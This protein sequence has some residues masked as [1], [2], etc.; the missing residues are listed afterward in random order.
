M[1]KEFDIY[2][3]KRLTKCDI[4]VYSIPYR[5]GLTAMSRLIL[6]SCL[7]EYTLQKFIAVQT[8]STL[9]SHIDQMIKTCYE[10]LNCNT[11]FDVSVDFQTHYA[12]YPASSPLEI[13]AKDVKMLANSFIEAKNEMLISAAPLL[14]FVGKSL[15]RGNSTIVTDANLSGTLKRSIERGDDIVCFDASV[16]ETNVQKLLR[17]D[18]P[19][20]LNAEVVNLCYRITNLVDTALELTASVLGTELHFS[21]GHAYSGIA[22]GV[23]VSGTNTQK[24]EVAQSILRILC[25]ATESIQQF[26]APENTKI[27]ITAD[28]SAITKRHRL[29]G[30]MDSDPVSQ[31]DDMSL[32]EVDY[33]LL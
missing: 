18:A 27:Y 5:D 8:G 24:F 25:S 26:F 10:R 20:I 19:I 15:G 31:Y 21:F 12:I 11:E 9:V 32:E 4:I 23:T 6:E 1:A 17:A 33:V 14:A 22:F 30:E 29:L 28:A 7:K 13:G 16:S 3:N 2:L